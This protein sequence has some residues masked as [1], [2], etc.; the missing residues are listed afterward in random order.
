MNIMVATL[1]PHDA[2]V[3]SVLWMFHDLFLDVGM[4]EL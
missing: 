3:S 1:S 4:G 2:V